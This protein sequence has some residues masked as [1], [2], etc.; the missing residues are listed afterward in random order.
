METIVNEEKMQLEKTEN[1]EEKKQS[2]RAS[3]KDD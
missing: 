3:Q 1:H 2:H